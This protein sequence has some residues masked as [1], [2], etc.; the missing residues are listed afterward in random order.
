MR[1]KEDSVLVWTFLPQLGH[2]RFTGSTRNSTFVGLPWAI[3]TPG[4]AI[5]CLAYN[6]LIF[7]RLKVYT[8]SLLGRGLLLILLIHLELLGVICL[9]QGEKF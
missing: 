2:W 7:Q 3:G 1:E 8:L 6:I 9:S 5:T 4:N